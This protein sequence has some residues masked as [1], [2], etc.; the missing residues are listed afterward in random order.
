M[1]STP[2][3]IATQ[4]PTQTQMPS[5]SPTM[6]A[7]PSEM[8]TGTATST[9]T[10][11]IAPTVTSTPSANPTGT[12]VPIGT[13]TATATSTICT[14]SFVDVPPDSTFYVYIQCLA[15]RG[16]I[17]GYA[18]HTFRPGNQIT[19]GQLS[20]IV[21][22]AAG[23]DESHTE[24]TFQDVPPESVFYVFIERMVSRGIISGYDCGGGGEPCIP[25]LNRPYFLP[26]NNATRGQI[27]KVVANAAEFNELPSTQTFEDVPP[28]GVFYIW[29]ERL[30]TRGIISGYSCGATPGEPCIPPLNRPYFLPNNNATRGQISKVVA[31]AFISNC[32]TNM[33]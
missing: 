11:P 13:Q 26:N 16:L 9:A 20:K 8:P 6:S 29:I 27:S 19:R 23:F 7:T 15:C 32:S 33:R 22:N 2:S 17:S 1:C 10:R 18:D 31:N 28:E 4:T 3:P 21:A 12:I 30:A 24:W 25:P 14:L 5:Y